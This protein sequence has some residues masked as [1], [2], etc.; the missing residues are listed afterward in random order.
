MFLVIH[1]RLT[2]SLQKQLAGEIFL[3]VFTASIA[4]A[5]SRACYAA[6]VKA[7]LKKWRFHGLPGKGKPFPGFL[8]SDM[9]FD[10]VQRCRIQCGDTGL[11]RS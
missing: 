6:G 8:F 4:G 10:G 2:D 1:I 9:F 11:R 7:V 5:F 3:K